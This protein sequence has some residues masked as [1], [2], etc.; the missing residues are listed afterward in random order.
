MIRVFGSRRLVYGGHTIGLALAQAS[1][2]LPNLATVLGWRSCD[3]TAPVYEGDTVYSEL[4]IESAEP[5]EVRRGTGIAFAGLR[6]QRSA[7]RATP[8]PRL[9]IH[10]AAVL[11]IMAVSATSE[12][13]TVLVEARRVAADVTGLLGVEVNAETILTGRAAMTT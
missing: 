12:W 13:A 8:S 7:G 2:L 5:T 11:R 4:H 6:V 10:G 9:A 1:K 3:H